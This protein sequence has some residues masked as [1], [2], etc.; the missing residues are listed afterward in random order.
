MLFGAQLF[1]DDEQA[2]EFYAEGI[3]KLLKWFDKGL[4]VPGGYVEK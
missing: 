2:A 1:D 4:D 3:G